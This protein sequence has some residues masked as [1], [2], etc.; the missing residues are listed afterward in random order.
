MG[1]EASRQGSMAWASAVARSP[2]RSRSIVIMTSPDQTWGAGLLPIATWSAFCSA[3]RR[4]AARLWALR[5][6]RP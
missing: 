6:R 4:A 5:E 1:L 2:A 3:T